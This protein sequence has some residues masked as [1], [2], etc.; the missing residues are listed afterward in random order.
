MM[1]A[2]KRIAK[3][4]GIDLKYGRVCR[5]GGEGV[6]GV[7]LGRK[8]SEAFKEDR[9]RQTSPTSNFAGSQPGSSFISWTGITTDECSGI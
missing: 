9:R 6:G 1:L 3:G 7:S 4:K 8:G 2:T 5:V